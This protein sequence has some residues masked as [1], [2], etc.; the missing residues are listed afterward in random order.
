M[1]GSEKMEEKEG[2]QERIEMRLHARQTS[3]RA[4]TELCQNLALIVMLYKLPP[5]HPSTSSLFHPAKKRFIRKKDESN[6]KWIKFQD[7]DQTKSWKYF[8]ISVSPLFSGF[9]SERTNTLLKTTSDH[10]I[11]VNWVNECVRGRESTKF[12]P[13]STFFDYSVFC[14]L[15][16]L[17]KHKDHHS[18]LFPPFY[19]NFQK[20]RS[21]AC[22]QMN[23][24][25]NKF[26]EKVA[27]K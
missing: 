18:F 10:W 21:G 2:K 17:N 3:K 8:R 13:V 25:Q 15:L 6:S 7:D 24:K 9:A 11:C 14:F 26:C 19:F 27:K 16:I 23:K 20:D 12:I 5:L 4:S 1:W 22:E